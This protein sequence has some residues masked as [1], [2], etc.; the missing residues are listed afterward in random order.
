MSYQIKECDVWLFRELYSV[1][2][3]FADEPQYTIDRIGA[4]QIAIPDDQASHLHHFRRAILENY[5]D[6]AN[7]E[8]VRAATEI[9]AIIDRR[10]RGGEAFDESFWTNEG[11]KDHVDW[12]KIRRIARDFL[13]R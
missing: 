8:V 1:L 5:P 13:V 7:L 6:L 2:A 4:G 3:A 11:F 10:S 9:D 12:L